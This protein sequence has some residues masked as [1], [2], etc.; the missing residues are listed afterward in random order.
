MD[1][2][3][4]GFDIIGDIHGCAYL[5][6]QLLDELGYRV[7][8]WSG[9]F[10]HSSRKAIFVGDLIDRGPSQRQVLEIV[11]GMVDEDAAQIV[12]GNHEF[13][14]LAYG[15]QDPKSGEYLRRHSAKNRLQHEA[16]LT[17]L[18]EAERDHYLAWFRTF[19]LWLDLG[20]LRVVHACWHEPS[21][22]LIE[23][24]LGGN[25]FK[26]LAELTKAATRSDSQRSLYR[27]VEVVLKGPE[28]RLDR[29]KAMPFKDKDGHERSEAR[30][31]WWKA[32]AT[33]LC[34]LAEIPSGSLTAHGQSYGELPEVTVSQR[35]RSFAY[36]GSVPVFY[37]HYW[38]RN[39]PLEHEDWTKFT[40]CV[41]FSAVKGGT[42]VAYRWNGESKIDRRNYHPHGH[43]VV[44][45]H[46]S[47]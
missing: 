9:V 45:R 47:V 40:A 18:T 33:T 43:A 1:S 34:E 3:V 2:G 28:L 22:R 7:D 10:K 14:A 32:G 20:K 6:E 35:D 29:Y 25:R 44:G 15:M 23:K 36:N 21:I 17:Q 27:S 46:P 26:S 12:M 38:R 13:N 5:L 4:Q 37:G 31:R 30:I 16:F 42:M 24:R 19:P 41:D 39:E 8:P 11:K